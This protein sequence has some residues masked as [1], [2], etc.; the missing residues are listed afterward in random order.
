[1]LRRMQRVGMKPRQAEGTAVGS[2][3]SLSGL[4]LLAL[5][6]SG[7]STGCKVKAPHKD[8][9]DAGPVECTPG[10]IECA[11]TTARTCDSTGHW[12]EEDCPSACVEGQ[13][14]V[15]CVP[16]RKYCTDDNRVAVCDDGHN[17]VPGEDCGQ[18]AVCMLG[19]CISK[20]DESMLEKSNVGCEFWA[21]DLDNEA[22][23]ALGG[24]SNDAAA[25]QYAVA[26]AN[27]NDYPVQVIVYKNT[28][29][30]GQP[31]QEE[32]VAQ[33]TVQPMDLEQINLPQREV[34][35]CMGQN[36]PYVMDSGSGTFV[37]SHAYHIVSNG[38][39]IA[40][41]FNPIIQK[42]SND[43]SILIPKQALGN[44]HIVLGWPTANF[45]GPPEGEMGHMQSIPDHTSVTIVG[46]FEDTHVTITPTHPVA[47]AS[48]DTGIQ[49][50]ETP[51]GQT[52]EV[53]IGPYD[54]VNIESLQ[55]EVPMG[56]C[57]NY[58]DQNGD[59]TGTIVE[60]DK[61]VAVFTSLERGIGFGGA[62]PPPAPDW[63]GESCCTDHL[64]QQLLPV[65]ALGWNFVISRSP[66]RS[67]DP[68]WREPDIYRVI[69]TQNG[70]TVTTTLSE[71]PQFQLDEGQWTTFW[72]DHGFVLQATGGAVMIEQILVSQHIIPN[73]GIGDPT[74]V[75]FPAA[76]QHRD[77]YVFLIPTTFEKNYM[78][79]AMPQGAGVQVDGQ[80]LGEFNADCTTEDIGELQGTFYVQL[81]CLMSEGVH[82]VEADHPV[83]LTVYGY[84]NVGSYGYPG[85]SDVRIIN[86]VQ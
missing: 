78:V 30:F 46:S 41:Q 11:G 56:E 34:D 49:I 23:D 53:T 69:A 24:M 4:V 12:S 60:S 3:L 86:P 57:I 50:P 62:E 28:A 79:L 22:Y 80:G 18:Q 55:P 33:V 37:S 84:Y 39:V 32:L 7:L 76:E 68:S 71:F 20:C 38:P 16:G 85:G 82:R 1:M 19:E 40:Y 65:T 15:D 26:V 44:K 47:A 81:T 13:G 58:T 67:T 29:N 75:I 77:R 83:G 17:L 42:F 70:T 43:A 45:C 9:V 64:E 10:T 21:V 14:C 48:G 73:G 52:I 63:D 54:V 61:P 31:V 51:A 36:G 5:F 8:E 74:M 35:G 6:F 59:F 72:A 66:V 27:V 2:S 25:E